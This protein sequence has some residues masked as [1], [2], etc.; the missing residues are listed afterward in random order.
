MGQSETTETPEHVF[1]ALLVSHL[2]EQRRRWRDLDLEGALYVQGQDWMARYRRA[3]EHA[4][5][6]QLK[7]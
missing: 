2:D 6:G 5:R 4:L 3:I 7:T 1:E